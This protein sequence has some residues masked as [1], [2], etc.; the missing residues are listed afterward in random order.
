MLGRRVK[1]AWPFLSS[2]N[3][4]LSSITDDFDPL[5]EGGFLVTMMGGPMGQAPGRVVEFNKNLQLVAEYPENPPDDGFNPHGIALR[6]ELNLMVTSDFV[7]PATTL[8]AMPGMVDF[9]GSIRVWNLARK[10]IVRTIDLPDSGGTIDVK[11]IPRDPRGRGYTAGMLDD[12]L[13]L[14]IPTPAAPRLYSISARFRKAAGHSSCAS[15]RRARACLS[16]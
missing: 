13:Y 15:T 3:P 10:M 7:C 8:Q 6:P 2:A 5:P 16:R 11:L 14:M 1:T 12:Q 9:R 4:P